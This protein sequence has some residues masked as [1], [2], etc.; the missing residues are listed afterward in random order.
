[1]QSIYCRLSKVLVKMQL[2][3]IEDTNVRQADKIRIIKISEY[4]LFV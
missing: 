2:K 4:R 1:M 3:I